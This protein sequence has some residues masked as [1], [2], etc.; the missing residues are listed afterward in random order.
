GDLTAVYPPELVDV[1]LSKTEAREARVRLLPARLMVYFMLGKALFSPDPYRE[2]L[3][4]LAEPARRKGGWG[5]WRIPDKAAVFRARKNLGAGPLRELLAQVEP[6]VATEATPGAYW[7][8]LRLMA[9]DGTMLEVADTPA[10]E[11]RFGRPRARAGHGPSGYPLARVVALIESGTHVVT[12][13]EI[14]GFRTSERDLAAALARGLRPGMLLL[15]DRGLPG[16]HLWKHLA[17]TGADLLWRVP[18]LWKLQ[19]EEVLADGSWIATVHGGRG[20]SKQPVEDVRVRVVEYVLDDPGR[21]PDEHYRLATTL[22]DPAI[23]SAREL[24]AL[25]A[26]RWE[27]ETTLAEWKTTQIGSGNVLTS[28]SPDLVDQ[29]IYAHL[30]VHAALR[31]LMHIAALRHPGPLDPDRLSF[32]AALRAARRSVTALTGDFFP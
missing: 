5:G 25:Y 24:A 17:A 28:K 18:K 31:S 29:E 16:V 2:V 19:P 3:R 20:R 6:G 30:A 15:A 13:A 11:E 23:A 27:A 22:M 8:G 9:V 14:G 32:A 26:E 7:R 12:D 4:K 1:V 21:D 10:N